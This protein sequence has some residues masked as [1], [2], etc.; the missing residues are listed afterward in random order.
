MSVLYLTTSYNR[1]SGWYWYFLISELRSIA[2]VYAFILMENLWE[3]VLWVHLW[4]NK[5]TLN[6]SQRWLC[7]LC[8]KDLKA[9]MAMSTMQLFC[10]L[11]RLLRIIMLRCISLTL[12]ACVWN[13]TWLRLI[14]TGCI[15]QDPPLW[16]SI[17]SSS[18]SEIELESDGVWKIV[19]GKVD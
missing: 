17:D 2:T 19:G 4:R 16:L 13:K 11:H 12:H 7:L 18:A 5:A 15:L 10:L 3:K 6:V 8:A 14:N 1:F 9:F